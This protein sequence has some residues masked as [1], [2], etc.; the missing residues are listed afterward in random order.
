MGHHTVSCKQC[1]KKFNFRNLKETVAMV[2][3]RLK[4][5]G[6]TTIE[7]AWNYEG[8]FYD[9]SVERFDILPPRGV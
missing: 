3:H 7:A 1:G 8:E 4:C 9:V 5:C 6:A 2:R